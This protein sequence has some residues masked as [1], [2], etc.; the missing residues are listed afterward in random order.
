MLY[1]MYYYYSMFYTNTELSMCVS[2][3]GIVPRVFVALL[4]LTTF[5]KCQAWARCAKTT[6][7]EKDREEEETRAPW[8]LV[9]AVQ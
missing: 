1:Y 4:S 7:K 8:C 6:Q 5:R 9:S 3:S 2:S